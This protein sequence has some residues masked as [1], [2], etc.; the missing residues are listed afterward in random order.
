MFATV[1]YELQNVQK[2]AVWDGVIQADS[3]WAFPLESS[4]KKRLREVRTGYTRFKRNATKL[5]KHLVEFYHRRK[6]V[7]TIYFMFGK[8]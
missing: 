1:E 6:N 2:E 7:P 3:Q 4:F 8:F 5:Q